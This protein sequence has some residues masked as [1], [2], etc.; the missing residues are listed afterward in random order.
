MARV[1]CGTDCVG[2]T[3]WDGLCGTDR[4]WADIIH[5]TCSVCAL[6]GTDCV[7]RTGTGRHH[8]WHVFRV[9][10]VWDGQALT[11]RV[12]CVRCVGRTG[13]GQIWRQRRP[14][15]GVWA[16]PRRIPIVQQRYGC[17]ARRIRRIRCG[18]HAC[19]TSCHT[20]QTQIYTYT[21]THIP[22]CHIYTHSM[23][24]PLMLHIFLASDSMFYVQC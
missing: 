19:I 10:A 17:V 6:C 3:V 23:L 5:G 1:P 24:W 18:P 4:H 21:H 14:G 15:C 22:S 16:A 12:P 13:T 7:G 8:P 11:A 2:R 9:C 20:P